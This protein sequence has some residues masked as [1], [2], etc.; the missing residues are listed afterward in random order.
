MGKQV[1]SLW[2]LQLWL[3][4]LPGLFCQY[5]CRNPI[6]W[7]RFCFQWL[8]VVY[9][10]TNSFHVADKGFYTNTNG[11]TDRIYHADSDILWVL[12]WDSHMV[13][14][15]SCVFITHSTFWV[16]T[17]FKNICLK[18]L[19]GKPLSCP[20]MMKPSVSDFRPDEASHCRVSEEFI[21]RSL[22]RIGYLPWRGLSFHPCFLLLSLLL[23]EPTN[24]ICWF[25]Q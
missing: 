22:A 24:Y 20:V 13:V 11:C 18:I 6:K 7:W 5:G 19:V 10:P 17:I 2:I 23:Q 12:E 8:F 14:N 9:V 25:H 21:S 15:G 3:A 1:L 16:G 4:Y